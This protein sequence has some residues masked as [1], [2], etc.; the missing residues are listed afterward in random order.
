MRSG[1]AAPGKSTVFSGK[2]ATACARRPAENTFRM[3]K[4]S[5]VLQVAMPQHHG[6]VRREALGELVGDVH[7]A[8]AP[9]RASDRDRERRT[10]VE[11][12]PRQPSLQETLDVLD[13][14]S[15]L[16]LALEEC[17][18][19]RIVARERPQPRTVV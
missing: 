5:L 17:D 4:A 11:H 13:E 15:R 9:A 12:E 7:R 18:H 14:D 6:I 19:L 2:M 16:R 8:M 1:S 3:S 10:L